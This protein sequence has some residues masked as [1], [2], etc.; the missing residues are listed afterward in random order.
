VGPLELPE[1]ER[2]SLG[3]CFSERDRERSLANHV[4]LP[5]ERPSSRRRSQLPLAQLLAP[6]P[7]YYTSAATVAHSTHTTQRRWTGR[8][9]SSPIHRRAS[10][11]LL[12]SSSANPAVG[13]PKLERHT[14]ARA[15][16]RG[17]GAR[18]SRG[19][20]RSCHMPVGV[21]GHGNR[22]LG[23]ELRVMAPVIASVVDPDGRIVRLDANRWTH[24]ADG[25]PELRAHQADILKAVETP[26]RRVPGR[27]PDEEWFY[28]EGNGPSRWLKV[29]VRYGHGK[30]GSIVTA[31]ARRSLP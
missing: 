11:P 13:R 31:F 14:F 28:L 2:V 23:R 18:P 26:S 6:A 24:I 4:V 22:R 19:L 3:A 1:G 21:F 7:C 5:Y 25:H 8:R 30:D 15:S 17:T 27:R 29:V 20:G 12:P 9:S 10:R 16:V